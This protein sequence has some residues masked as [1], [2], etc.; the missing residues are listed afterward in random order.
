MLH[1][2]TI[3]TRPWLATCENASVTT[4]EHESASPAAT[5][6]RTARRRPCERRPATALET[7]PA[8]P[9]G[10]R[11]RGGGP[12][13]TAAP[14]GRPRPPPPPPQRRPGPPPSPGRGA[15]GR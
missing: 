2:V 4:A 6:S 7:A 9:P 3:A 15:A 10:P 12:P 5:A 13:A 8:R 14:R 1:E 11:G